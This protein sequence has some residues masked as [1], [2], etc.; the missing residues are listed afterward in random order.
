M[1]TEPTPSPRDAALPYTPD[2]SRIPLMSAEHAIARGLKWRAQPYAEAGMARGAT[3][4]GRGSQ[5]VAQPFDLPGA[6]PSHEHS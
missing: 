4:A 1:S 5:W 6:P 2:S 3:R